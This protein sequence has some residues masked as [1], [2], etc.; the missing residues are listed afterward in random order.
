MVTIV[1]KENTWGEGFRNLGEGLTE[2]YMKRSDENAVRKAVQDLPPN[3]TPRELLNAL[4]NVHTYG[5]ESKQEA[6]K[7]YLGV[8][9]YENLEKQTKEKN[10]LAKARNNILENRNKTITNK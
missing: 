1:P 8:A 5:N 4:T 10:D 7:N 3:S 6:F 2:G 9:N